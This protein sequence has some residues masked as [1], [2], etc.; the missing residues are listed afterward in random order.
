MQIQIRNPIAVE[1]ESAGVAGDV[2]FH[3]V[4]AAEHEAVVTV[5]A[6]LMPDLLNKLQAAIASQKR[7]QKAQQAA[8]AAVQPKTQAQQPAE[9]RQRETRQSEAQ[10][11]ETR[12][13]QRP[14]RLKPKV[15][16]ALADLSELRNFSLLDREPPAKP[17]KE[18]APVDQKPILRALLQV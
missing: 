13:P 14:L 9:T 6:E 7:Q 10:E 2:S 16:P 11:P 18:Y 17:E 8:E 5:S 12:Q 15:E 1:V 3:F 4:T